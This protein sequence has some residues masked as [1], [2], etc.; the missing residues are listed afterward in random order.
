[1]GVEGLLRW[2]TTGGLRLPDE[3]IQ[4]AER[5]G[6]IVS[7]G[8]FVLRKAIQQQNLWRKNGHPDLMLSVNVSPAE[9]KT[10]EY[11]N[12]LAAILR[13]ESYVRNSLMLEVTES[14][15]LPADQSKVV[16]DGICEEGLRLGLCKLASMSL[17]CRTG[18]SASLP[19][20]RGTVGTLFP[21]FSCA[22]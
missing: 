19:A 18:A 8:Q 16:L 11:L 4:V 7:I 5:S 12:N 10:S 9:L 13:E 15:S 6:L 14:E 21:I 3:F 1:V 17:L 20:I 2:D 22:C